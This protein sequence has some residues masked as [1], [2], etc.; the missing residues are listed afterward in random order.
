MIDF[1]TELDPIKFKSGRAGIKFYVYIVQFMRV[2]KKIEEVH[3]KLDN[4]THR[5]LIE[6][7]ESSLA[8]YQNQKFTL[9]AELK[10]A[11]D[12]TEQMPVKGE[13]KEPKDEPAK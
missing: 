2:T 8:Y 1:N 12:E 4:T 7:L 6:R 13:I 11:L 5:Q 9:L 3:E 10:Q